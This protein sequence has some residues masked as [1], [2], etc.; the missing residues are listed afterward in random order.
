LLSFAVY[1]P[2][3]ICFHYFVPLSSVFYTEREREREREGEFR[4][5][6]KSLPFTHLN[7]HEQG[8]Q[9][10]LCFA[11]FSSQHVALRTTL[12]HVSLKTFECSIVAAPL[13]NCLSTAFLRPLLS[14]V[15]A[16]S[17]VCALP[18]LSLSRSLTSSRSSIGLID[19][20][21]IK[22]TFT[23]SLVLAAV[24]W[25]VAVRPS[26]HRR[27]RFTARPPRPLSSAHQFRNFCSTSSLTRLKPSSAIISA[28]LF[29]SKSRPPL[30][31]LAIK[32]VLIF[33]APFALLFALSSFSSSLPASTPSDLLGP[34]R[35]CSR[36]FPGN[37]SVDQT[38]SIHFDTL[39]HSI[40]F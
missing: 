12:L 3:L 21:L 7:T 32:I 2:R 11:P 13:H 24:C 38:E 1:L 19:V 16:S 31:C 26:V 22:R 36:Q 33:F 27:P 9:P 18:A 35:R 17:L 39:R 30:S 8:S 25:T 29:I 6:H 28:T 20:A 5:F 4:Y 37:S 23:L 40:C 34:K 14:F 15:R 10:L